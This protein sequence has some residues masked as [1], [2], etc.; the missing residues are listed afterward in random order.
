MFNIITFAGMSIEM[1]VIEHFF[2]FKWPSSCGTL[3]VKLYTSLWCIILHL[4]VICCGGNSINN[5]PA[6]Y[7]TAKF[8]LKGLNI[9]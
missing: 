1:W 5:D 6:L 7:F 9:T 4:L 3:R 8:S 2:R